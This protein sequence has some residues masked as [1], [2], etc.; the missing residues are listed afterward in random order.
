MR[1]ATPPPPWLRA[2]APSSGSCFRNGPTRCRLWADPGPTR[3]R[4]PGTF[5][6]RCSTE[7]LPWSCSLASCEEAGG[8]AFDASGSAP[9]RAPPWPPG[10]RAVGSWS[11]VRQ[12]LR[13]GRARRPGGF[14]G[15]AM[16]RR[17]VPSR[18]I[19]A[20]MR[21]P[22]SST[23]GGCSRGHPRV[24]GQ[25]RRLT[26]LEERID[27]VQAQAAG[28]EACG[29]V[30]VDEWEELERRTVAGEDQPAGVA[31]LLD[32]TE[33]CVELRRRRQIPRWKVRRRPVGH[34]RDGRGRRVPGQPAANGS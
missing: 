30:E 2:W 1:P 13:G 31:V 4:S 6:G 18:S 9:M 16:R 29:G 11:G 34:A 26:R 27:V 32:E 25:S 19:S 28:K 23:L 24:G 10:C 5:P 8:R 12:V 15:F 21:N 33:P 17:R 7:P 3:W 20:P 14:Y 22:D